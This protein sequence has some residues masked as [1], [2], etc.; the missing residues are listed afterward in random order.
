MDPSA[1]L[2]GFDATLGARRVFGE[3]IERDG[4][5]LVPAARV[6]GGGGGGAGTPYGNNGREGSGLGFGLSARPAG[7]FVLDRGRVH[8]EP[9]V[10]VNRIVLGI[11]LIAITALWTL[12]TYFKSRSSAP[13]GQPRTRWPRILRRG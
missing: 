2:G 9:A 7:V 4:V 11:Q 6:G 12:R 10:D 13:P 5:L 8:W 3:P 1:I